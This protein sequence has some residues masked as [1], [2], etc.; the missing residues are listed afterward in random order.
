MS[1]NYKEGKLE[2]EAKILFENG[3][4]FEGNMKNG[5]LNGPAIQK[6]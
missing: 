2:G 5:I 1:A 3:T 4:I 6:W